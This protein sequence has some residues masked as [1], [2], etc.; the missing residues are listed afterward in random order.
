MIGGAANTHACEHTWAGRGVSI[1]QSDTWDLFRE[2][3][4]RYANHSP[5]TTGVENNVEYIL[6][7]RSYIKVSL[8]IFNIHFIHT[9]AFP[10]A[11]TG[12]LNSDRWH[13]VAAGWRLQS[14]AADFV[15]LYGHYP[16]GVAKK[17]VAAILHQ[18]WLSGLKH[19]D[20]KRCQIQYT[21]CCDG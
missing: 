2:I 9:R 1:W 21:E 19:I 15:V 11:A 17:R 7:A 16:A 6:Y 12:L 13:V 10:V 20:A 5:L 3:I 14:V 8:Y 18:P 4:D